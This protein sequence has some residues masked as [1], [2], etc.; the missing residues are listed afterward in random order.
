MK[1]FIAAILL[2]TLT[3]CSSGKI[4]QLDNK[5]PE[6]MKVTA[7]FY[8]LAFVAQKVGGKLVKVTQ[9]TP[10][11][12][13][14]HDYEPTPQD[15]AAISDSKVFIMSGYGID[16]WADNASKN[17]K[18]ILTVK[19]TDK[20]QINGQD[21]HVW[22]NPINFVSE[23]EVV[24]DAFIQADPINTDK[25][26]LNAAGLINDLKGLDQE[27]KDGLK[28]CQLRKII[29]SH[30]AFNYMSEQYNFGSMPI[31]GISPDEEPSPKS[32]ADLSDLA[33]KNNIKY[34][35]FETLVSPKLSDTIAKEI[36]AK[37]L[38]LNPIEGVTQDEAKLGKDYLI[39]MQENLKNLRIALQCK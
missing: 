34:I 20:I 29:T 17:L 18:N 22:L 3:G 5:K 24:R 35:F 14:P 9:I 2:I 1:K 36:G 15:L 4:Q 19:A 13:E 8:P 27:F 28:E 12:V 32:L 30:D 39:L 11:G 23:V 26:K 37:S 38:V 31:A 6:P 25:Y 10:G 33:K 7:S 16:S 21:P